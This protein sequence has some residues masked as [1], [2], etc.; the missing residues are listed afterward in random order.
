MYPASDHAKNVING[1]I[2]VI[3]LKPN[4]EIREANV[5][6]AAAVILDNKRYILY[7]GEF[8]D[9]IS[10]A[11]GTYWG[12]ISILAHEIGHHLNGH[13]LD[14]GGSR[15]ATELESDEFSGFVLCKMGAT[16]KE[17]QA[18][19]SIAASQKG[20]HTHPGRQ[21]RL[22]AIANGWNNAKGQNGVATKTSVSRNNVEKPVLIRRQTQDQTAAEKYI[23]FDVHFAADSNGIYYITNKGNLV[24]VDEESM[25]LI[26]SLSESNKR[27][28]R[29]MLTDKNYNYL[30]IAEGGNIENGSGKKVGMIK[31]H[32]D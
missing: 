4:F 7:N 25:Y 15:P 3:G 31:P 32:E 23:A 13:T 20:S 21:Q 8:M 11:S 12:G 5:P 30:Y 19:I 26:G 29:L 16:L 6:N 22:N 17:A 27:G 28:Y 14:E 24:N 18:A 1:V 2:S 10:L 9:Q